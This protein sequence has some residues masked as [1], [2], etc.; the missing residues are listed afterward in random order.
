MPRGD[1]RGAAHHGSRESDSAVRTQQVLIR[2]ASTVMPDMKAAHSPAQ[3]HEAY[4]EMQS[5][6]FRFRE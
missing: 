1:Q 5:I 3:H 6:R 4:H 2:N